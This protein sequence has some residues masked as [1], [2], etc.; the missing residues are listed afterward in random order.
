MPI[1]D[2]GKLLG[3][4][5]KKDLYYVL[6]NFELEK[7]YHYYLLEWKRLTFLN[8]IAFEDERGV[9]GDDKEGERLSQIVA[10]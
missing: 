8:T 5:H 7:V 3:L 1:V 2:K 9:L 10:R 4:I 6:K